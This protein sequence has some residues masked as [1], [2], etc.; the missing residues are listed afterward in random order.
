MIYLREEAKFPVTII[1]EIFHGNFTSN[2][3][4][5]AAYVHFIVLHDQCNWS[6]FLINSQ[7]NMNPS[8]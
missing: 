2:G 6:D 7:N 1:R 4:Q 3:G 5:I 8:S